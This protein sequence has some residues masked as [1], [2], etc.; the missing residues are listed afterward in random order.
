MPNNLDRPMDCSGTP[1]EEVQ[2]KRLPTL[3]II[4]RMQE[5]KSGDCGMG[6]AMRGGSPHSREKGA[7]VQQPSWVLFVMLLSTLLRCVRTQ[8]TVTQKAE[9]PLYLRNSIGS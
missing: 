9:L 4:E 2:L 1:L 3:P 5:Q 6:V 7:G 8:K